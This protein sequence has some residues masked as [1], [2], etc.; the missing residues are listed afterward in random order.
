MGEPLPYEGF[1]WMDHRDFDVMSVP[2][3]SPVGYILQVDL[4]YPRT[5]HDLH[6]DFPFAPEHRKAEGSNLRRVRING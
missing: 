6:S 1:E 5:L 2:D 3:D 4:E